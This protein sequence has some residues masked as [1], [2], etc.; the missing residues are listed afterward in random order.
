MCWWD[1]MRVEEDGRGEEE[2]GERRVFIG[3]MREE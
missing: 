1:W 3:W 2:L